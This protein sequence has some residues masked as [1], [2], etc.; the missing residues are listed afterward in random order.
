M[1]LNMIPFST[2]QIQSKP[3]PSNFERRGFTVQLRQLISNLSVALHSA[4]YLN[5]IVIGTPQTETAALAAILV[6]AN[7]FNTIFNGATQTENASLSCNVQV[8][9]YFLAI[10]DGGTRSIGN[11]IASAAVSAADYFLAIVNGSPETDA[12]TVNVSLASCNYA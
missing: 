4:D 7:Y 5:V 10:V 6:A 2:D 12:A 1:A 8:L 3:S 11:P 9:D